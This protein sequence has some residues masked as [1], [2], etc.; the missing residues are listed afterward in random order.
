MFFKALLRYER[1]IYRTSWRFEF[2][3]T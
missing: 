1:N 3:F 2:R